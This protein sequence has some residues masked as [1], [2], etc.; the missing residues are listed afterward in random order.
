MK[1]YKKRAWSKSWPCSGSG[2][3]DWAWSRS[4][5]WSRAWS[6][7]GDWDWKMTTGNQGELK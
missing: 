3:W 5:A 4:W 7:A 6:W 1:I 2:D